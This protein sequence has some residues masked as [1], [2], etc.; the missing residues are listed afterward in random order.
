MTHG[1]LCACFFSLFLFFF[2]AA[3]NS[4][5]ADLRA[6]WLTSLGELKSPENI[7]ILRTK[8]FD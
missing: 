8:M 4:F 6:Y 5:L 2:S 1:V 7:L 3:S